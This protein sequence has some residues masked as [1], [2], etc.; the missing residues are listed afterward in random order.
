ME[1]KTSNPYEEQSKWNRHFVET[2]E[3]ENKKER[4]ENG[5]DPLD[6]FINW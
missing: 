3:K 6:D 5:V 4:P 1:N 2:E